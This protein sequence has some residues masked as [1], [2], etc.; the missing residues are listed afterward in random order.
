MNQTAY[1]PPI[2]AGHRKPR[3]L[4]LCFDGTAEEFNHRVRITAFSCS[5]AYI[6]DLP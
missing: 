4:V 3:T 6:F 5:S 2:E 1:S